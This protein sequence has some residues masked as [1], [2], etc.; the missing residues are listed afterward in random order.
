MCCAGIFI[1]NGVKI[2]YICHTRVIKLYISV[3]FS[4]AAG[5]ISNSYSVY[6]CD[7]IIQV[8][9][10]QKLFKNMQIHIIQ[11]YTDT[12]YSSLSYNLK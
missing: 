5:H 6:N 7:Y 12:Y 1:I 10:V 4:L 8:F 9:L 3:C 2:Y 11:V